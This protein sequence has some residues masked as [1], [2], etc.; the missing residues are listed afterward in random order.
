MKNKV[1]E[2]DVD[3]LAPVLADLRKLSDL[4]KNNVDKKD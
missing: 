1:D 4:V 3:T 2:L